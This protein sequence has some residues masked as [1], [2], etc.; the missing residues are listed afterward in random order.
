[1]SSS[2]DLPSQGVRL[3]RSAGVIAVERWA[4][5]SQDSIKHKYT[6]SQRLTRRSAKLLCCTLGKARNLHPSTAAQDVLR[7]I[8][9]D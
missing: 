9:D 7:E 2:S 4:T 8:K 3:R 5:A 6:D 1:M